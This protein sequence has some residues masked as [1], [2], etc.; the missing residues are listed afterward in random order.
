M[1]VLPAA[2]ALQI[3]LVAANP[4]L[5]RMLGLWSDHRRASPIAGQIHR[6]HHVYVAGILLVFAVLSLTFPHDLASGTGIGRFLSIV[7]AVFWGARFA[8][9][10]LYYDPAYLRTHRLGDVFFSSVFAVLFAI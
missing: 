7:M 9:Q 5:V 10:R 2:A 1:M 6:V 4:L 8:V 3:G